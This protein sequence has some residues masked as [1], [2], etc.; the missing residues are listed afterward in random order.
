MDQSNEDK[1]CV[2]LKKMFPNLTVASLEAQ[3]KEKAGGAVTARVRRNPWHRCQ[4]PDENEG[5]RKRPNNRRHQKN[6]E[7]EVKVQ[8]K[9]LSR[10]RQDWHL[11]G[12][13]VQPGGDVFVNTVGT[14]GVASASYYWSRVAS[15][16]GRLCQKIPDL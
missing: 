1:S 14:F 7:G 15:A 6:Y 11:V 10:S 4:P 12:F 13:Q 2:Y 5:S 16:V 9:Q 8:T 3:R